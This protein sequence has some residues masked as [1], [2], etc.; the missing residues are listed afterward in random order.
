MTDQLSR[1]FAALADPT[2]RDMVARLTQ[3]DHTVNDLA[4]PFLGAGFYY[5]TFMWPRA[6]WE[7]LYEPLI[8]RAAGLGHL[9]PKHDEAPYERAFAFCD[10]LVIGSGPAGLMAA[11]TAARAGR[12]VI[13]A[14]ESHQPGGRLLADDGQIGVPAVPRRDASGIRLGLVDLPPRGLQASVPQPLP[15]RRRCLPRGLSPGDATAAPARLEP[16]RVSIDEETGDP[17]PGP[18]RESNR[19][20]KPLPAALPGIELDR[21][22][23][24]GH[25]MLP[26]AGGRSTA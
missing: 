22:G 13:L 3:G 2:R 4:A 8:R 18:R 9:D 12:Q 10:L 5:K 20:R 23:L 24:Q 1:V 25:L 14:E 7:G 21:Y 15:E 16:V 26:G 17:R 11:L 6:F 19:H